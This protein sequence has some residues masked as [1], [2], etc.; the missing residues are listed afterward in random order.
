M[1]GMRKLRKLFVYGLIGLAL[2]FS[3]ATCNQ[4]GP[5]TTNRPAPTPTPTP[6][7]EVAELPDPELPD[8]IEQI[9]PTGEAD[10]LAQIRVRFTDPLIPVESLESPDRTAILEKFEIF[11]KIPGQFRFL[12]PRMV[13]FQADRA[14]PKATR[15]RITLKAGLGDLANHQLAEDLAW[16]FTTEPI[17][18]SNLP[19]SDGRRGSEDNPIDLEPTL[20]FD[21]NIQLDLPSLQQH[22]SL[23]PEN[24]ENSVSVR[25]VQAEF[26]DEA[27]SPWEQFGAAG[28][29]WRYHVTPERP[30]E[31]GARY[32]LTISPGLRPAGG[33]LP[34]AN[35]IDSQVITYGFLTFQGLELVG[36]GSPGGSAG[37]FVNGLAQLKFNNGLVADSAAEQITIDP[38]PK[39]GASLVR[40]YDNDSFV[41][42][43]PWALEPDT[44]YTITIGAD[45]EDRFGQT[46]GAPVTVEYV[47][48]DLSA[49]LW[50]PSGLNIFPAAQDLQLNLSAVNL[51]DGAYK[52]A[53]RVVQPSDLVNTDS[54]YPRSD[55]PNLLPDASTWESFPITA[56]KNEIADITVPLREQLGGD[57]GM[58]A[59]GVTARTT[60]YEDNGE[61]RWRESDHY[62]LVQLTNLGV[63]AQWFP[64]SG[65]VRAHHLSDGSVVGNASVS[66]YRSYLYD[67]NRPSGSPQPC[68][69]GE[70][71]ETG[72]LKLTAQDLQTCMAGSPGFDNPPE[73]LV[74]A[75]EGEDWSFVRTL[76]YSG[77]YG[78]GVFAGWDGMEPRSRGAVFSDRFLYQPGETAWLTG[79]A[80]YLQQGT[81]RQDANTPYTVTLFGPE[82]DEIDLGT[83]TTNDFGSFSVQWDIVADQPLGYYSISAKAEN[84]VELWGSLRVAEFKPPNFQ[85]DLTLDQAFATA[86]DQFQAT[87]QSDYLFGAPVQGGA[88]NYYVTR[89]PTDVTPEGWDGFAFG[90]QWFWPDLQPRVSS[91]VV[92]TRQTLGDQGQS[93]L[94]VDVADDLPYP[95]IY[96]VDAE[97]VDVSNLSVAD[98]KTVTVLPEDRLIGLKSDF[99]ADAGEPFDVEV[100]VT[101]FEGQ[102]QSGQSVQL[103]LER[104]VYS[105]VTEVIEGSATPNYQ[106]EYEP[107]GEA[108]VR[109]GSEVKTV[110]LTPREAGPYRIRA[111]FSN[112]DERSATDIRIWATGMTPVAWGSRFRDDRLEVRLDKDR[113]A[114][115]ETATVLFESPYEAGELYFA[116]VRNDVLYEEV[117]PVSGG[118]PQ[119]QFTVTPDM[120]PNASVEAVLVRQ[121]EPLAT[122]EPN[123][124]KNL[125]TIGFESFT[126]DL[127]D[128][129]LT[130]EIAPAQTEIPPAAEQTLELTLMDPEGQPIQ[131][132]FTVMVVDEAVL[133]LSGHRP[134][135]LV[136][137]VYAEQ[138][139]STR[140]A[141]NRPEVVLRPLSSPLGKGWGYGGGFSTGGESTRI[142]KDFQALAYYNGSVATDDQGRAEVSFT[143]PDNLTTWRVMVVATDGDLRFGNSETTF[144]TTQPLITA[145]VLPQFA[146]P[147]DHLMAG[148]A[149]TNTTDQRGQ[150]QIQGDLANG[151]AFTDA[152]DDSTTALETRIQEGTQA[153]RFPIEV[154]QTGEAQVQFQTQLGDASDGFQVSLPITPLEITEQVVEAGTTT[155]PVTIPLR[156]GE[157]VVPDI[158]GLEVSLSSTLL[159]DI[160]APVRQMEWID[161]LPNLSTAASQLSIA[162]N[163]QILSQQYGQLDDFDAEEK[164]N[165]AIQRIQQLQRPDGGLASWPGFER[166]DPFVTAY[167]G[168]SLAAADAAGFSVDGTLTSQLQGYLSELLANPGQIDG[169]I[170][171]L[172]KR[173]IRL[174]T[175]VALAELGDER[176]DFLADLY[177]Q[178]QEFDAVGQIK[179]ARQLSRFDNWRTE[180]DALAS[181]IQESVYET[182]QSAVVNLPSGWGWFYSPVTAQAQALTLFVS[183]N[184]DPELLGRLVEGLL[185]LRQDGAWRT[186]YD[187]AQA[188]SALATYAQGLPEPPNFEATVQLAGESLATQQFEG[189]Q[190]PSLEVAVPMADLPQGES[191]LVL[192]KSG[193]GVLHYL[194]AYRYRL[195][196][197]PPGRLQGLRV[198]RT[199]RA[200][201]ETE[202]L[203]QMGLS[204]VEETVTLGVGQVFDIGLEIITDHPVNHVIINDPL[205]A[206]LEAVDTAFQTSTPYFQAQQDSWGIGY[207]R[208]GR[209]RILAYSDHLEAG[210]YSL[211]YLV[212]SVTPGTFLWPGSEVQLEYAP[213]EFGRAAAA[214]LE[215][216]E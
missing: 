91:E 164:A 115:G 47:P 174:E 37:R 106:A 200:A 60:P 1:F 128:R 154:T 153:Y 56:D 45:L 78:Y 206:G 61:Q 165:Q 83:Q 121:G 109:S 54:A 17:E 66:I 26:E 58:L 201:N 203:Y 116:V 135:D 191:E 114:P 186:P 12:T 160:K 87:V 57:T 130:P 95:M 53:Y 188:L 202:T 134:P 210:V 190:Q 33:N 8:W 127:A 11:P 103:A 16:T 68:A 3:L 93:Q 177:E 123:S 149:V 2:A 189:Y 139:I 44:P 31:K 46:L 175:L 169:C 129:Y 75:R 99:V 72:V 140:F 4:P 30:L 35:S 14:I 192:D 20:E 34:T 136:E 76:P 43:N 39:E 152:D 151:L 94:S 41:S 137:T 144:I 117:A 111:T 196:D 124:L 146:R 89:Q 147:G 62:G 211:H 110:Q 49:D 180:A 172:C 9:S 107:V 82:G 142:R 170:S 204:P 38:P 119:V 159:T 163:L 5:F 81:L 125:V 168:I 108:T 158:G 102:T 198:T 79:A 22:L 105:S 97:V 65:Q 141:D 7:A 59:Y 195:Q 120:L 84:G 52:A 10:A 166:S 69:A 184:S 131:G 88:V 150:L 6:L 13:G 28:R 197:N 145:P 92:E 23:T 133:Q 42:I 90:P 64:T 15:L 179:L 21:S 118:A 199:L 138:A 18:L 156:V 208:L 148:L 181:E 85:V 77:D 143:L 36:A 100:I 161:S 104:I 70:T 173:Q 27:L 126:V 19:G 132:Q 187:N 48:G 162:A 25:V 176:Q 207:Q 98:S 212:R 55:R 73:L 113:Y 29:P 216:Q 63:F 167:A 183:R 182:A 157:D 24:Q 101:N 213:E 96:R 51:P 185:A 193:E 178:R 209:D 214:T 50:A 112:G 205:P 194:T 86:D 74:V 71:D 67:E 215:V 155:D 32:F 40:A 171:D 122:L 80:Y